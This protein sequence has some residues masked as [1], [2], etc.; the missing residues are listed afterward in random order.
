MSKIYEY[1]LTVT[2]VV[3]MLASQDFPP[4]ARGW[5]CIRITP[6]SWLVKPW[7]MAALQA[8]EPAVTTDEKTDEWTEMDRVHSVVNNYNA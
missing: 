5:L 7:S 6:R 3:R 2:P 1:T 4:D 8:E